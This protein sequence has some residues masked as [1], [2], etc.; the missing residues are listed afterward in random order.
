MKTRRDPSMQKS[1]KIII[2]LRVET[3][4]PI[5]GLYIYRV[6]VLTLFANEYN[7]IIFAHT[8]KRYI[9]ERRLD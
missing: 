1:P 5:K 3:V 6:K 9:A 8:R 7:I 4:S 2:I